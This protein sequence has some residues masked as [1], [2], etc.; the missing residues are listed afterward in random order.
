M[1][2]WRPPKG[3]PAGVKRRADER[4]VLEIRA[5]LIAT[6]RGLDVPAI[7]DKLGRHPASVRRRLAVG[8]ALMRRL[9]WWGAG[10]AGERRSGLV[11]RWFGEPSRAYRRERV[12]GVGAGCSASTLPRGGR[13]EAV[14]SRVGA[15]NTAVGEAEPEEGR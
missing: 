7:A 9:V 3:W 6:E 12:S 1:S 10:V 15:T 14:P 8:R 5:I 4:K 2:A 11:Q 13:V